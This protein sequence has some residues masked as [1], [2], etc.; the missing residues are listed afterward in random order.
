MA[1]DFKKEE[2]N[3]Y[4]SKKQPSL[5][6]VPAL[7]FLTIRGMGDP[8]EVGGAYQLALV[9]LYAVAYALRMS[10]KTDYQIPGYF[11]YVVPPLEGF[12]WQE[13][14]SGY[15]ATNKAAFSWIACLRLPDFIREEDVVW[16]KERVC[17]KKGLDCHAIQFTRIEEGL[18]VQILHQRSYDA[19]PNSVALMH[20]YMRE[21]G[22]ELDLCEVRHH[23]E[24]YLSDPNKVASD[25]LK[26]IVRHPIKKSK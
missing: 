25:K 10:Y 9:Q 7:D 13:G 19:E 21:Q 26:T 2:K 1:Y 4:A 18:C 14:M 3:L 11:E 17:Q 22:Y 6:E 16:A 15:D 8:N 20:E 5:V 23:H 24:I 12:W